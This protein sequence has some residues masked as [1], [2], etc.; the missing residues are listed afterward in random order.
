MSYKSEVT[1]TPS[2]D[3]GDHDTTDYTT[4]FALLDAAE[5]CKLS[6]ENLN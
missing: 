5:S 3:F 4:L 2:N 6:C 1:R